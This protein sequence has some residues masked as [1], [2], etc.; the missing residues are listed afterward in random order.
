V[1]G[2]ESSKTTAKIAQDAGVPTLNEFFNLAVAR[3]LGRKFDVINAAGVFFHLEELHS[4]SE[5]IRRV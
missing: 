2:V 4:V 1:L 3:S 5:G